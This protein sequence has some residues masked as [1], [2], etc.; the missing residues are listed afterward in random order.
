M[1]CAVSSVRSLLFDEWSE[2]QV[3]HMSAIGNLRFNAHHEATLEV[4]DRIQADAAPEA[5]A[6]FVRAKYVE[7]RWHSDT[8]RVC[9]M[10]APEGG[11]LMSSPDAA[12]ASSPVDAVA[13]DAASAQPQQPSRRAGAVHCTAVGACVHL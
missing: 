13:P 9:T 3:A 7:R 8:P 10:H 12:A 1:H 6:A 4:A 2:A 5:R 11:E